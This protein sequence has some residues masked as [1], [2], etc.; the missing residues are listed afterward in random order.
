M[1]QRIGLGLH[2]VRNCGL[3]QRDVSRSITEPAGHSS[4][5][6][7]GDHL[8]SVAST[9][10][11]DDSIARIRGATALNVA[12]HDQPHL[13]RL[14]RV[15]SG[16]G[17]PLGLFAGQLLKLLAE[18]LTCASKNR[19]PVGMISLFGHRMGAVDGPSA[20]ADHD[21][22]ELSLASESLH[23]TGVDGLRVIGKFREQDGVGAARD[24]CRH[25][26]DE[27]RHRCYD[28]NGKV[29]ALADAVEPIT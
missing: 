10:G 27:G 1:N 5:A 3:S 16:S 21:Q 11:R 22:A 24:A 25:G 7:R 23:D 26:G 12:Q 6:P 9:G 19:E 17:D 4:E 18:S 8:H 29:A 20:L 15:I 28:H 13:R 14:G 2:Q